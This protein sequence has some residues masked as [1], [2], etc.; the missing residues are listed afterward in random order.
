MK[1]YVNWLFG[2]GLL[3]TLLGYYIGIGDVP[4]ST[5]ILV[6]K[7]FCGKGRGSLAEGS[8]I[9]FGFQSE[10]LLEITISDLAVDY[11]MPITLYSKEDKPQSI[12]F[13]FGLEKP[14]SEN[15]LVY[16]KDNHFVWKRTDGTNWDL[17]LE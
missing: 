3:S 16:V 12:F 6:G 5:K 1:K 11:T 15:E 14:M 9:C 2:I 13:L 17:K 10:K 7:K 4:V 8:T